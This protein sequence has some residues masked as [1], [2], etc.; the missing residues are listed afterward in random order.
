MNFW[1]CVKNTNLYIPAVALVLP[2]DTM[3]EITVLTWGATLTI[4]PD[5][6]S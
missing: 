6:S 4:P 2:F 5:S 3:F 1:A